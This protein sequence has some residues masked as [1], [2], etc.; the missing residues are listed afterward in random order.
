MMTTNF[1]A[2]QLFTALCAP[3][4]MHGLEWN[5][6]DVS[7]WWAT[8]KLDGHRCCWTGSEFLTR[9]GLPMRVPDDMKIW[10]PACPL[11]GE[12][13]LGRGHDHNTVMSAIKRRGW[14]TLR[15]VVFDVPENGL[16][17]ES[18]MDRIAGLSLPPWV[19]PVPLWRIGSVDHA[20]AIMRTVVAAGGEGL[21]LRKPGS[22]YRPG[23]SPDLLKLKPSIRAFRN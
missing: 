23:R 14:S 1:E 12:M 15:Y 17:Y 3:D 5:R 11:D 8:E 21:M 10:M 6:D 7:G 20:L 22:C 2:A 16:Q 9:S 18:A 4:L 13:W 19:E